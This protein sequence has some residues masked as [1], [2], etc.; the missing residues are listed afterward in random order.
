[1][2]FHWSLNDRKSLPVSRALLSILF[3]LTFALEWMFPSCLLISKLLVPL[4]SLWGQFR[5][6]QLQL[7]SPS[8]SCCIIDSSRARSRYFALIL[9]LFHFYSLNRQGRQVIFSADSL[10]FV[11]RQQI[12][13]QV[14]SSGW[15]QVICLYLKNPENFLHDG[16]WVGKIALVV[17][18]II[19]SSSSIRYKRIPGSR[20]RDQT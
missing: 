4:P 11:V 20:L 16:F 5:T 17:I 15:D 19:I 6:H 2:L 12:C 10:L 8:C 3:D 7:L 14:C 13:Q 18:I 9:D 1:M